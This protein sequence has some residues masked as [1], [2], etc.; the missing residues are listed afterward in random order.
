MEGETSRYPGEWSPVEGG[1]ALSEKL[2]YSHY[3][4]KC[5]VKSSTLNYEVIPGNM[6][7]SDQGHGL[8]NMFH[9]AHY[10]LF[11]FLSFG[12]IVFQALKK[13]VQQSKLFISGDK[14]ISFLKPKKY[15]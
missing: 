10:I 9:I 3:T 8:C 4:Y 6:S 5:S 11:H 12:Y 14:T 13:C 15:V 2:N 7:G 1:S